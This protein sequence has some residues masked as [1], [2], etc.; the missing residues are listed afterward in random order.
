MLHSRPRQLLT[1]V[2]A[3]LAVV[4]I[5]A[6]PAAAARRRVPFGF[7][8]VVLD[9]TLAYQGTASQIDSQMGLM[10]SSGVESVRVNFSWAVAQP[11]S[12]SYDWGPTDTLVSA[13]ARHGLQL[14]PI[15]EFTPRWASSHP[16]SAWLY[17]TPRHLSTFSTFMTALVDRYGSHGSFWATHRGLPR[18]PI[19]YWQIWNEPEGTKYDWRSGPLWQDTY[20][21][22]LKAGFSAVHRADRAARVVSGAVVALNGNNLTPWNE[23]RLL[24]RAG[25]KRY[26]DVLAV[27]AFTNAPTVS[28]SVARSIRIVDLVRQVMG[29]NR[30]AGKPVW[31]TEVTWTAALGRIPRSQYA[32]F[33]TTAKGQAQRL[34]DYYSQVAARRPDGIQRAFWYTWVSPYVPQPLFGNPPTFQYSGLVKWQPGQPF[35]ALPV[36][37]TYASVAARFEGCRKT[38]DA[39]RCR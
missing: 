22:L 11:A 36:L 38:T 21:S 9:P 25:F 7:F 5:T 30:D 19:T 23:A 26:F 34:S 24:Y 12:D 2:A 14:L 33:E 3:L 13:A 17:Y 15:V 8:G 1:L 18:D 16:Q 35:T 20:T 32:G 37:G 4:A 10:A 27:N 6:A 29:A 31:V 39:R 28:A